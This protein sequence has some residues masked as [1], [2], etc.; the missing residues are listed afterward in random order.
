MLSSQPATAGYDPALPS[1]VGQL[2]N[3][4]GNL[5]DIDGLW[6]LQFGGDAGS[7]SGAANRLYFT[8]GTDDESHGLLGLIAVPEPSSAALLLS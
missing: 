8:A 4:L 6:A 3:S 7:A 2:I 1:F 5:L